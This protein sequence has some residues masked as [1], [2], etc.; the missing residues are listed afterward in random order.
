MAE[1][2]ERNS[3]FL[4]SVVV[5]MVVGVMNIVWGV[6]AINEEAFLRSD[7]LL[8]STLEN[9]GYLAVIAGIAQLGAAYLV[10]N[11][12]LAGGV[13]AVMIAALSMVFWFSVMGVMPFMG[14]TVII[15][16]LL[17]IYG[18]ITNAQ[19]FE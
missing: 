9:W 11:N 1:L 10:W 4:F 19:D 7:G 5:F 17:I 14:V 8:A 2:T 6:A 16:A 3:W 15:I 13:I 18:L 12:K